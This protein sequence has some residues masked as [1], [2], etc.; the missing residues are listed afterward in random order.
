MWFVVVI[1]TV[2]FNWAT[3]QTETLIG[4]L[5]DNCSKLSSELRIVCLVLLSYNDWIKHHFLFSD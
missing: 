1:Y 2:A 4:I 3:K 5:L